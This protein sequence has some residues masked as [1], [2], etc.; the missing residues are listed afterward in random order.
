[1]NHFPKPDNHNKNKIK[2]EL[3]FS[4]YA[5][6]SDLKGAAGIDT[7]KFVWRTHWASLKS[8]VDDLDLAKFKTVPVDSNNL[9]NIVKNDVVKKNAYDGLVKKVNAIR[10]IH[11]TDLVKE[12]YCNT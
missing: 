5:R 8:D 6:K 7:S 11:T 4:N 10:T 9:S 3:H 12:A 1:M 2:F